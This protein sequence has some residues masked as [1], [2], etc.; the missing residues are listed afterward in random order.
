M[1][2]DIKKLL[3]QVKLV[4]Q[5]YDYFCEWVFANENGRIHAPMI[6][7]CSKAKCRQ[8][9]ID[10]KGI[11]AYRKTLNS[12][13]RCRGVSATVAASMLGHTKEVNEQ[14]YTF[15]VTDMNERAEIISE[16]NADTRLI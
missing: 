12:N 16:I 4:E 9:G 14:Y 11:H 10:G 13:L 7:A 8:L 3:E 1:T 5:K 2:Q 6:S 15:D